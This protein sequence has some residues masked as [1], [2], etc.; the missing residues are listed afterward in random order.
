MSFKL[1]FYLFSLYY[2]TMNGSQTL[3]F[4]LTFP[5]YFMS[6]LLNVDQRAD[7][8]KRKFVFLFH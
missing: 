1:Y 5:R 3:S 4:P 2:V 7:D 8:R 6:L